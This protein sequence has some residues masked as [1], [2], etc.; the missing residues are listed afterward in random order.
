MC[1]TYKKEL[2]RRYHNN[3][4][5]KE[6]KLNKESSLVSYRIIIM[7]TQT[8]SFLK[9]R[10]NENEIKM[11]KKKNKSKLFSVLE[12]QLEQNED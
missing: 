2:R 1:C 4:E 12:Q 7:L 8:L 10:V 11:G 9:N 5:K 3:K 6:K